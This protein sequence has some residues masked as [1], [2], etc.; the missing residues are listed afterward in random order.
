MPLPT[1]DSADAIREFRNSNPVS[2]LSDAGLEAEIA[3][4][5]RQFKARRELEQLRDE[6]RKSSDNVMFVAGL[7]LSLLGVPGVLVLPVPSIAVSLGGITLLVLDRI[8]KGQREEAKERAQ[9]PVFIANE[10][11]EELEREQLIREAV[12]RTRNETSAPHQPASR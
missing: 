12:R 10:R 2:G 3:Y 11:L 6:T 8:D 4:W 9:E 5:K 1:L 7:V